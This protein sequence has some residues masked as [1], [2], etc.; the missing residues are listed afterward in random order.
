[1][2]T[3]W[4]FLSQIPSDDPSCRAAVARLNATRVA[5]GLEPCSPLT[6]GYG[7]ELDLHSIKQTMQMDVLRCKTPAMVQ[8]ELWGY[9]LAYNLLRAAMAQAILEHGVLPRQVSLQGRGRR[10]RLFTASWRRHPRP[11]ERASSI[12]F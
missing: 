3:L 10:W 5:Q 9:L 2:V 1:V 11:N 6:G 8:K 4:T 7:A 12:L